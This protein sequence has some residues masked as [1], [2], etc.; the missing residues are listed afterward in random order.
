MRTHE[1]A[2]AATDEAV[3]AA[4]C[5]VRS[6]LGEAEEDVLRKRAAEAVE[7]FCCPCVTDAEDAAEGR[8]S[9]IHEALITE[10]M[11]RVKAERA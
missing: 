8:L 6:H 10:V 7:K 11:Q 5:W 9:V 3:E 4:V 2:E 1:Y